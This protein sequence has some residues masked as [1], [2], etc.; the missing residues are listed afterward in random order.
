M[1]V[2]YIPVTLNTNVQ[3]Y[4]EETA[5]GPR[6]L[7]YMGKIL[8]FDREVVETPF[9]YRNDRIWILKIFPSAR[10]H[11]ALKRFLNGLIGQLVKI[12]KNGPRN[13]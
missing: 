9:F 8:T 11:F 3:K 10:G 7:P 5:P 1:E 6:P 12:R 2:N 13:F 4:A